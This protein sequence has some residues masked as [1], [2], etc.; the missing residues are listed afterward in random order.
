M[1][2][3]KHDLL[4]LISSLQLSTFSC[5][6][7]GS[8][9]A[10]TAVWLA[11]E[12]PLSVQSLILCSPAALNVELD[13]QRVAG[14]ALLMIAGT[15]KDGRGDGTGKLPREAFEAVTAYFFGSVAERDVARRDYCLKQVQE[16]C[17]HPR[18]PSLLIPS[19][20]A[21]C[22]DRGAAMDD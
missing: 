1:E 4:A 20:R 3:N 17:E 2:E 18:Q 21:A 13:T 11:I 6:G 14:K 10:N 8:L 5:I 15:N 19:R 12:T 9:G 7:H 16:R 22:R